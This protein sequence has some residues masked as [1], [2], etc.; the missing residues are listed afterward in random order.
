MKTIKYIFLL[1][2]VIGA[3]SSCLVDNET[4]YDDNDTGLNLAGFTA[5][6]TTLGA[7]TDGTDYH[8][9][10]QMKVF[11]PTYKDIKSPVTV[12]VGVDPSSTAVEGVNF[13]LENPTIVLEP[14]NNLLNNFPIT[15]L[16]EG[17]RAPLEVAPVIRLVVTSVTGAESVAPNG[18]PI[19]VTINYGCFSDLAGRYSTVVTRTNI[20]GAVTTFD[21][22]EEDVYKTGIGEYHTSF[23]G[24]YIPTNGGGLGVGT[25]GFYFSDVCD[26]LTVPLQNLNDYYSNEVSGTELGSANPET[27]ILTLKYQITFAA[28]IRSYV[29]VYTP[30]P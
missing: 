4:T 29:S 11:G 26:V 12:T 16:T 17:I 13:S 3:V 21:A 2:M 9:T 24:H 10:L 19:D 18:K 23:V 27:G 1:V 15:I 14:G 6:A 5:A 30:V 7:V 25:E 22:Y 28:G 20:D 8:Y